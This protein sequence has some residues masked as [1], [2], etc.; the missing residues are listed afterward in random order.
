MQSVY[1]KLRIYICFI[2]DCSIYGLPDKAARGAVRLLKDIILADYKNHTFGNNLYFHKDN[3]N[4]FHK[5][6]VNYDKFYSHKDFNS[7][8]AGKNCTGM[9]TT[10][11]TGYKNTSIRELVKLAANS[12]EISDL[13]KLG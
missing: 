2:D 7:S 1:K 4:Y 13:V 11:G 6:N 10:T 12:I 3:V 9:L 5:D 8:C